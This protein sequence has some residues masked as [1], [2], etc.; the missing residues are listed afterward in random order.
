M[1]NW[2]TRLFQKC[3]IEPALSSTGE[4]N[5]PDIDDCIDFGSIV[6]PVPYKIRLVER[7]SVVIDE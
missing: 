3:T 1:F 2:M 4:T 6:S 5:I 7:N